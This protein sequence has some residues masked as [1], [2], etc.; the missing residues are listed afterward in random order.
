VSELTL[1]LTLLFD[2]SGWPSFF[3]VYCEAEAKIQLEAGKVGVARL[4]QSLTVRS[5]IVL[6]PAFDVLAHR[7]DHATRPTNGHKKARLML[8]EKR[9]N[10]NR[11]AA[12]LHYYSS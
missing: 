10:S 8:R 9:K 6:R 2:H 3:G 7:T 4:D 1:D 11:S 12:A 5:T